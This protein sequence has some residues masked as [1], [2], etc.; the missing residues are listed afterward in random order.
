VTPQEIADA[1][2]DAAEAGAAMASGRVLD[3]SALTNSRFIVRF[4]SKCFE[5]ALLFRDQLKH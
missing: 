2:V 3:G 1:A 4:K 5:R